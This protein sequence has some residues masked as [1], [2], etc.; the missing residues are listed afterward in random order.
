[1]HYKL[2]FSFQTPASMLRARV[3]QSV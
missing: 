2:A 3:A 1:M